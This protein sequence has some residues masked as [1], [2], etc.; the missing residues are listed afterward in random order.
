LRL[1]RGISSDG[2]NPGVRRSF[3]SELLPFLHP[4]S[5]A[6][7]AMS[8]ALSRSCSGPHGHDI[9]C[10]VSRNPPHPI[11]MHSYAEKPPNAVGRRSTLW[12]A[13]RRGFERRPPE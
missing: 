11:G 9:R 7:A 3:S 6:R 4:T 1:S 5:K 10:G 2:L 12:G 13:V 8:F